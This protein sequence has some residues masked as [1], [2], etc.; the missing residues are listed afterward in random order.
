MELDLF[1]AL[2]DRGGIRIRLE[3]TDR[4][5]RSEELEATGDDRLTRPHADHGPEVAMPCAQGNPALDEFIAF[6]A[7]ST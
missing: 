1:A 4:H 3:G 5:A 6:V 7:T 2:R